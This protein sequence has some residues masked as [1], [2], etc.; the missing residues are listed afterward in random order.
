MEAVEPEAVRLSRDGDV[1]LRRIAG[2]VL[3]VPVRKRLVDMDCVFVLDGTGEFVWDHLDGT[4][5]K[6]DLV[7]EVVRKFAVDEAQASADVEA[8][9]GELA[10]AGLLGNAAR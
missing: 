2:E 4:R 6:D 5:T 7:R 8:F 9:L 10:G 3:L 1:V